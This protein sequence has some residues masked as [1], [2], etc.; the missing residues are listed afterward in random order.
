VQNIYSLLFLGEISVKSG[1]LPKPPWNFIFYPWNRLGR[2]C[3]H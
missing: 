2:S 1:I 3:H